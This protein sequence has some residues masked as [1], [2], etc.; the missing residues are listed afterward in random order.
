MRTRVDV[1]ESRVVGAH[2]RLADYADLIKPRIL[3]LNLLTVLGTMS[4]ACA[5][6]WPS[7]SVVLS[8]LAGVALAA[9]AGGALNCFIE[10]D[11]DARMIRTAGRPLPA[12]RLKPLEALVFGTVLWIGSYFLL[13]FQVNPPTAYLTMLAFGSYVGLYTPLKVRTPLNTLAGTLPGALPPLIGWTAARGQIE[14]SGFLLFAILVLW[15]I[16]HFLVLALMR[17]DEYEAAGMKMLPVVQGERV[18]L[19]QILLYTSALVP[20]S[21]LPYG[22]LGAGPVYLG[23]AIV[24]GGGF[25]YLAFRLFVRGGEIGLCRKLFGYSILYLVLIFSAL[26]AGL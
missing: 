4:L 7:V 3:L 21:L 19:E 15:Q 14:I 17:R 5:G 24:L 6:H 9:G 12:G 20:V 1:V 10:R 13:Y 25:L 22:F 11:L 23:L 16:P 18:T 8:T 2:Q 26:V